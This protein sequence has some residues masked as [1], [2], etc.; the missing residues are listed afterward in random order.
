MIMLFMLRVCNYR[1]INALRTKTGKRKLPLR[2]R[3]NTET[4]R[5]E[6]HRMEGVEPSHRRLQHAVASRDGNQGRS[7]RKELPQGGKRGQ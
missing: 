2:E 7:N 5:K 1:R 6:N 3:M 4:Q